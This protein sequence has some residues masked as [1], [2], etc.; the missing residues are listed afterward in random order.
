MPPPLAI[1]VTFVIVGEAPFSFL[2]P[3]RVPPVVVPLVVAIA[4]TSSITGDAPWSRIPYT[5]NVLSG[6]VEIAVTCVRW[7]VPALARIA[8]PTPVFSTVRKRSSEL[9]AG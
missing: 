1:A 6:V 2:M 8:A 5:V 3:Y 9:S 7:G 4:V